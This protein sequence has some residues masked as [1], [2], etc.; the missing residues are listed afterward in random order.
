MSTY[1]PSDPR[2]MFT[3]RLVDDE[4]KTA[5]A[6]GAHTIED[7]ARDAL[8]TALLDAPPDTVGELR[9]VLRDHTG[10]SGGTLL[11]LAS[12]A[13]DGIRWSE[14]PVEATR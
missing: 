12:L 14:P 5:G 13:D 1:L 6:A 3:W 4:G 8:A 7:R 2:V 9:R 10:Y 11:C